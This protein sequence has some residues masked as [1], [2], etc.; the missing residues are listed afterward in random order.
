MLISRAAVNN[1]RVDTE[2][3]LH[4]LGFIYLML[5]SRSAVNNYRV[6]TEIPLHDLV[7]F[8][9]YNLFSNIEYQGGGDLTH[10]SRSRLLTLS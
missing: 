8:Q 6:D 9:V 1:Y 5:I 10:L 7:I 3:P 2:I 4:D